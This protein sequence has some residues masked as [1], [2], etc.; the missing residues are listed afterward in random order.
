MSASIL[1]TSTFMCGSCC[2]IGDI[3]PLQ[4]RFVVHIT[5][6]I[7]C[8]HQQRSS[9]LR[10]PPGSVDL[11]L[12]FHPHP[13]ARVANAAFV[14]PHVRGGGVGHLMH[15]PGHGVGDAVRSTCAPSCAA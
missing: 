8:L 14:G 3:P 6:V 1:C 7:H 2:D 11:R 5:D 10:I 13:P 4:S 12:H 9:R 15:F